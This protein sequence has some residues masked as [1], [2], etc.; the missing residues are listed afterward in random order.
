MPVSATQPDGPARA[1]IPWRRWIGLAAGALV[2]AAVIVAALQLD[3]LVGYLVTERA[4]GMGF[5]IAF[6]GVELSRDRVLLRGARAR[7]VGV[8]GLAASAY[9]LAIDLE[10]LTPAAVQATGAAVTVEASALDL[11]VDLATWSARFPATYRVPGRAADLRLAWS[12]APA[13][14]PFLT[15][16]RSDLTST[17]TGARLIARDASLEGVSIGPT[18][19]TWTA[20]SQA[21]AVGL[22]AESLEQ[23]PLRADVSPAASPPT[24]TVVLRPTRLTALS[25]PIGVALPVPDATVEARATLTLG[26]ADDPLA[27]LGTG[28]L[29]VSGWVPPHPRELDGVVYGGKT[30]LA[31]KLRV[32]GAREHVTLSDSTLVAGA[33]RLTGGG[34]IERRATSAA[35]HMDMR[36]TI[37]CSAI[38]RSAASARLGGPLGQLVGDLAQGAVG[39]SVAVTVRVDADTSDLTKARVAHDVGVGCGLRLR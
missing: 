15:L 20:S 34:A 16:A 5:E 2:L 25:G 24:A 31:S 23:A 7:L 27:V 37:P 6:D 32:D 11:V 17:A 13:K 9:E 4:R 36:G 26:A 33:L 35:I 14:P 30:L 22:G 38:A 28:E 21:I 8:R 10:D 12:E 29:T 39:G 3:A 19:A 18:H 1:P